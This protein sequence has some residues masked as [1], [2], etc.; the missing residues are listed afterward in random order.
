M[1]VVGPLRFDRDASVTMASSLLS[2]SV[3]AIVS[4]LFAGCC[5]LSVEARSAFQSTR[6]DTGR[7]AEAAEK[8]TN[9]ETASLVRDETI[10]AWREAPTAN[11][12]L[13]AR[14]GQGERSP[15]LGRRR[16]AAWVG[17]LR[18]WGADRLVTAV[19]ERTTGLGR[20][21]IYV[22]GRLFFTILF[23]RNAAIVDCSG[24]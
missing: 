22:S 18:D 1:L 14:L 2:F 21:E 9:C 12:I 10:G 13:V 23:K 4:A 24:I 15:S 17:R 7:K 3:A 20:V 6:V 19:G 11:I 5:Q 8:P 16:L